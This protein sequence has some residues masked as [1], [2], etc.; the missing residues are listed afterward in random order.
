MSFPRFYLMATFEGRAINLFRGNQGRL[1][2]KLGTS[3]LASVSGL[4]LE[5][6][7]LAKGIALGTNSLTTS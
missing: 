1:L 7:L 2:P 5:P 4:L 3:Y 6:F